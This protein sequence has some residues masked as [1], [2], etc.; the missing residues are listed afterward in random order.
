[1]HVIKE[2][3]Y[4]YFKA[5]SW[6]FAVKAIS[7]WP[8]SKML[9]I[10]SAFAEISV[11]T[12]CIK[13][14]GSAFCLCPFVRL[15]SGNCWLVH[16][17]TI[18]FVLLV[19]RIFLP[20]LLFSLW[21]ILKLLLGLLHLYMLCT[22]HLPSIPVPVLLCEYLFLQV[23][24][25]RR[26]PLLFLFERKAQSR[27]MVSCGSVPHLTKPLALSPKHPLAVVEP[28]LQEIKCLRNTHCFEL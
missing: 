28:I 18:S 1:M 26:G 14:E 23:C 6:I 22:Q 19:F 5:F 24:F 11:I 17:H 20:S 16:T 3:K 4:N 7:H 9:L 27:M 25:G 13:H 8:F 12:Y 10:T 2:G 15:Y 21:I